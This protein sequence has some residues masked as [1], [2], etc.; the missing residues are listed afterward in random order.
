M[1]VVWVNACIWGSFL[2]LPVIM[3]QRGYAYT[4]NTTPLVNVSH[5]ATVVC[6]VQESLN[7]YERNIYEANSALLAQADKLGKAFKKHLTLFLTR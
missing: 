4:P 2:Y 5:F 7:N 3:G 1:Y 6:N